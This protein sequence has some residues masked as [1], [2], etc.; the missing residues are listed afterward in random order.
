[1]SFLSDCLNEGLGDIVAIEGDCR[2]GEA[3]FQE[4]MAYYQSIGSPAKYGSAVAALKAGF[5]QHDTSFSRKWVPFSPECNVVKQIGVQAKQL[6]AQMASDQGQPVP[7]GLEEP[8]GGLVDK[9]KETVQPLA[10]GAG[11]GTIALVAVGG[12][13]LY[14]HVKKR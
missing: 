3:D 11:I 5:D 13:V 4:M 12:F 6:M 7:S 2:E 1:M 9:L 8:T 14:Q 10:F